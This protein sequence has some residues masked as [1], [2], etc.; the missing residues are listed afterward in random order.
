MVIEASGLSKVVTAILMSVI[1]SG[2]IWVGD[3][4]SR[5]TA[6]ETELKNVRDSRDLLIEVKTTQEHILIEVEKIRDKLDKK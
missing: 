4:S 2:G 1:V 5:L 6:T 3:M